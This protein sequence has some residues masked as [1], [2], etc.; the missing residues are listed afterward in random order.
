MR[1]KFGA[2]Y[3]L[4]RFAELCNAATTSPI[5]YIVFV[6]EPKR[7]KDIRGGPDKI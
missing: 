4:F 6:Y 1:A 2:A 7:D 5:T 3:N